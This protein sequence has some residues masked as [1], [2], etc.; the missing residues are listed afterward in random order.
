VLSPTGDRGSAGEVLAAPRAA[1]DLVDRAKVFLPDLVF[2]GATQ[3]STSDQK[4][5]VLL[6]NAR[7]TL[8]ALN[9]ELTDV[10]EERK[11]PI[12]LLPAAPERGR[13][14]LGKGEK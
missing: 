5:G 4:L 13:K 12:S 6:K 10:A 9:V 3:L 8:K 14:L 7:Q 11:S 1:L 2:V